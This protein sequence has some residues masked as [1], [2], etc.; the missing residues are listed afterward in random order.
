[1]LTGIWEKAVKK[2]K[3]GVRTP[4]RLEDHKDGPDD[5]ENGAN[6]ATE[7]YENDSKDEEHNPVFLKFPGE[8]DDTWC[9]K[10][11]QWKDDE[12]DAE[13]DSKSRENTADTPDS[14]AKSSKSNDLKDSK[15]Q[16][17]NCSDENKEFSDLL[18]LCFRQVFCT[19]CV[20]VELLVSERVD[21]LVEQVVVISVILSWLRFSKVQVSLIL[22]VFPWYNAFCDRFLFHCETLNRHFR[23]T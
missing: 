21:P 14:E 10:G 17:N 7:D 4:L 5:Y 23:L 3:K 2:E 15:D 13:Y 6:T 9:S 22:A 16:R 18:K 1:M 20:R 12:N 8:L 19:S 11:N